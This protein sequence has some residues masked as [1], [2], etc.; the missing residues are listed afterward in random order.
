MD[1]L[2][3]SISC[4]PIRALAVFG[5]LVI[6]AAQAFGQAN[7]KADHVAAFEIGGAAD[8]GLTGGPAGLGGTVAVEVTPIERWL[9]LE[10]GVTALGANGRKELSTDLPF[11]KPFEVLSPVDFMAGLGPELSWNLSGPQH[12]QSLTTE[13]ALDFMIWRRQTSGGMSSRVTTSPASPRTANDRSAWRRD[14]SSVCR[15]KARSTRSRPGHM[16]APLRCRRAVIRVPQRPR[17]VVRRRLW[18]HSPGS[19]EGHSVFTLNRSSRRETAWLVLPP[20]KLTGTSIYH[21]VRSAINIHEPVV[22]RQQ[23]SIG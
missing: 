5:A 7:E 13:F 21:R 3:G 17:D 15:D 1:W 18:L 16:P 12:M 19:Y 11:K 8:W 9:E 10:A 23:G 6:S 20:R 22:N 4:N 14:S 2:R